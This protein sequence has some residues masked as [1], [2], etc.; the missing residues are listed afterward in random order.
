[1][2]KKQYSAKAR[3]RKKNTHGD[4]KTKHDSEKKQDTTKTRQR[5]KE[6][7]LYFPNHNVCVSSSLSEMLRLRM[8]RDIGDGS[9]FDR[10]IRQPVVNDATDDSN[11]FT[12]SFVDSSTNT[13]WFLWC[14]C[15]GEFYI[16]TLSQR[17]KCLFHMESGLLVFDDP[18]RKNQKCM[19]SVSFLYHPGSA[20]F[21]FD[22]RV[23]SFSR[24]SSCDCVYLCTEFPIFV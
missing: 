14:F 15:L 6:M 23:K 10:W 19:L 4:E 21:V 5:E 13:E 17:Y 22:L 1:M 8:R 20:K 24:E 18:A 3:Q 2:K 12:L 16:L 9:D 7:Y 11:R